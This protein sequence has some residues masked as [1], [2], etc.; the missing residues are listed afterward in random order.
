MD[1]LVNSVYLAAACDTT[2]GVIPSLWDGMCKS[3]SEVEITSMADLVHFITNGVRIGIALA[4]ILAVI[5]II[6]AGLY[7]VVSTGDPARIKKAKDI[8]TNVVIGLVLIIASYAIV[9]F[10]SNGF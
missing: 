7:Y 10:I 3:G 2:G 8:L 6:V 9:T 1:Q 4:G 5:A